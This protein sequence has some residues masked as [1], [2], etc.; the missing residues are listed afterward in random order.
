MENPI[1]KLIYNVL[2]RRFGIDPADVPKMLQDGERFQKALLSGQFSESP[3]DRLFADW[4]AE[5]HQREGLRA[6]FVNT[7]IRMG[8]AEPVI[9]DRLLHCVTTAM[10]NSEERF[11]HLLVTELDRLIVWDSSRTTP[12]KAAKG[13]E[14]F[15]WLKS[16]MRQQDDEE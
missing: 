2:G 4:F 14:A 10:S 1:K 11:G 16:Q 3:T 9:G 7:L 5:R 13:K 6:T 15:E 12:E 8:T